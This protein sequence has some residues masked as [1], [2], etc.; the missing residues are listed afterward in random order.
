M[1]GGELDRAVWAQAGVQL[2]AQLVRDERSRALR[3][4]VV[5]VRTRL[6]ADQQQV[7]HALGG[8][9]GGTRPLALDHGVRGHRRAVDDELRDDAEGV[10]ALEHRARGIVGSGR[11]L[12]Q[13]DG[14]VA[15][16]EEVG[17]RAAD[18]DTQRDRHAGPALPLAR[19]EGRAQAVGVRLGVGERLV[20]HA[21]DPTSAEACLTVPRDHR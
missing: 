18:I 3:L 15:P 11:P 21:R 13:L 8:D 19:V 6:A 9:E 20:G 17:E 7:A 5:D 2:E 12:V 1:V 4:E 14:A 10:D 16:E